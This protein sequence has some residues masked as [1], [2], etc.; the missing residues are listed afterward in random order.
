M[1]FTFL[2]IKQDL[3][4]VLFIDDHFQSYPPFCIT[5]KDMDV[6]PFPQLLLVFISRWL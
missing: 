2:I 3:R 6:L 5:Y 1:Y 4:F